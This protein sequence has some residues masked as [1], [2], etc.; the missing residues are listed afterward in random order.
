M[1]N[2]WQYNVAAAKAEVYAESSVKDKRKYYFSLKYW[3]SL[4]E[5]VKLALWFVKISSSGK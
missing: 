3:E 5:D 1:L 4:Q 2:Q